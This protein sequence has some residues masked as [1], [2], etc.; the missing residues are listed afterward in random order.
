MSSGVRVVVC[1][2]DEGWVAEAAAELE[3][4]ADCEVG[5]AVGEVPAQAGDAD[6]LVTD[7]ASVERVRR[8]APETPVICLV[9]D[10]AAVDAAL[11]DGATDVVRRGDGSERVLAHR[12]R[13]VVDGEGDARGRNAGAGRTASMR[14]AGE[15]VEA[16]DAGV[17]VLDDG[18]RFDDANDALAALTGRD[19]SELLGEHVALVAGEDAGERVDR[20]LDRL[21]STGDGATVELELRPERGEPTP[22]EVDLAALDGAGAVAAFRDV[23]RRK[24]RRDLISQL[25]ETSRALMQAPSRES[26]AE[27]AADAAESLLGFEFNIVRLYDADY[28]VL[29]PVARTDAVDQRMSER[30]VYD[31]DE[32][33]PGKVFASGEPAV[34]QDLR[35]LS[36]G[37]D[38]EPARSAM[39]FPIGVHG[40]LTVSTA[41]VDAIDEVDRRVAELL[42]TNAAAACNRAKRER[43]V[44]QARER[45]ATILERINGLVEDTVEVLVEATTREEVEAGVPEQLAS[46][47]PYVF[48]WLGRPD[49]RAE[50]IAARE[51]SGAA[52]LD[53]SDVEVPMDGDDPGARAL[54]AGESRVLDGDDLAGAAGW[55]ADAA[56]AG[57]ASVMA[58]PLS[59]T[60]TNYGVLYVC[61]DRPDAFDERER[62]VLDAL[63]Q[64]V[65]N[66][67]NAIESGRILSANKVIELEF[68][69]DDSD[70][71]FC[72]LTGRTDAAIES[73]GTV[74]QEEGS[75]RL[76]LTAEGDDAGAVLDA[77]RADDAVTEARCV[78]E[79]DGEALFD[80][81]VTE[82]LVATLV[83]HGAVPKAIE[84]ENGVTRYGVELPYEAEAR[85]V[86]GL[87]QD[88]Y[89]NTDLVGYHEHERPVRTQ[90]EFRSALADRFTG[91][92]E[93]ALRTAYL[94][95]FFEWPREVDGDELAEGM[96]ISRPTYHQH[97]RAAQRKVF[98]ELFEGETTARR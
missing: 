10:A 25:Q 85:E 27:I 70:L 17:A 53:V 2:D 94:G 38:R 66:A 97:L 69:V 52:D 46:A 75:L 67:I 83:D 18:G 14:E 34:V 26:I 15:V 43:E 77:L 98:E 12:I 62:V 44:R 87:V 81:T 32:G 57:V 78:A 39:Y 9:D 84:S 76:Y 56:E 40:T 6:C 11:A 29:R 80:A 49:V 16:L 59:Y 41:T 22:F 89:V 4:A 72:R 42:A 68:T 19:R 60:D 73:A 48:A 33:Q 74:T 51:W 7:G 93:T 92:Q 58:V 37:F 79:H 82:S 8:A 21:E 54:A 63:G 1:G 65:A 45:I 91:R 90:Q 23:S 31:L 86:F 64:A 88:N 24:R 28:R 95:G 71:L 13:T 61:A 47:D 3:D 20:A 30:P 36:D 50:T 35:A 96:D 5:T 55:L